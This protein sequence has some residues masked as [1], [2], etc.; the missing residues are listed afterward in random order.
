[1]QPAR[2]AWSELDPTEIQ[3]WSSLSSP[4][5]HFQINEK[6]TLLERWKQT[7]Q[8][9]RSRT[10]RCAAIMDAFAATRRTGDNA[11]LTAVRS[12]S[13]E[14]DGHQPMAPV[15]GSR[16]HG[17]EERLK[18][19]GEFFDATSGPRKLERATPTTS[20]SPK[21]VLQ[22]YGSSGQ[23]LPGALAGWATSV[24]GKTPVFSFGRWTREA[25][26]KSLEPR[27]QAVGKFMR[28]V[29]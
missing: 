21:D 29:S 11:A 4:N 10:A 20:A 14:S 15:R 1:M 18:A 25:A 16:Q 24:E 17:R 13:A 3:R 26:D 19:I 22:A 6:E 8:G 7:F 23:P 27:R 2:A 9:P 12:E 5:L 28:H